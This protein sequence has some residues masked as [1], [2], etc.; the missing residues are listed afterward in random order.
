LLPCTVCFSFSTRG[1]IGL[2]DLVALLVEAL[3]VVALGYLAAL[4]LNRR[5]L[6]P[7]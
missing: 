6:L 4:W 1:T 3:Y 5:D 7:H 2:P